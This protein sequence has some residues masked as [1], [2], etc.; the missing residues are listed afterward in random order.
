MQGK[1]ADKLSADNKQSEVEKRGS[2][3][4]LA[5]QR[6][7]LQNEMHIRQDYYS[8]SFFHKLIIISLFSGTSL[9]VIVLALSYIEGP[10]KLIMDFIEKCL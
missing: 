7:Y 9:S 5:E 4:R 2:E 8:L 1:G 10:K 3:A 6:A